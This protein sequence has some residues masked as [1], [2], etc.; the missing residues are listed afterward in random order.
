LKLLLPAYQ[1]RYHLYPGPGNTHSHKLQPFFCQILL[2]NFNNCY[3]LQYGV[4]G[5]STGYPP[6]IDVANPS[7]L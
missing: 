5:S 6:S 1:E 4:Y 2:V 7:N 3:K